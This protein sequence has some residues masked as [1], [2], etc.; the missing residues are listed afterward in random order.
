MQTG[1]L[2]P[3]SWGQ[4]DIGQHRHGVTAGCSWVPSGQGQNYRERGTG[5]MQGIPSLPPGLPGV[6][7]H[8]DSPQA[9]PEARP[10]TAGLPPVRARERTL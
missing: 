9:H 8:C 5:R 4:R 6:S 10:I 3:T 7:S 2:F 1:R